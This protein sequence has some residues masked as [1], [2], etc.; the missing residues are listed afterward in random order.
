MIDELL[1]PVSA[2]PVEERLNRTAE[3]LGIPHRI[4]SAHG[5]REFEHMVAR[6]LE[7]LAERN[8]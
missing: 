1:T 7:V 6:M 4:A 5:S 8:I 2:V 3:L